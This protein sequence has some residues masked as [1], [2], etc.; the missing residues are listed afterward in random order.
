MMEAFL[1][2]HMPLATPK[3]Y[4]D[5]FLKQEVVG[6]RQLALATGHRHSNIIAAIRKVKADCPHLRGQFREWNDNPN[7]EGK[8]RPRAVMT[9]EGLI[10]VFARL[11]PVL[12]GI[13]M[14]VVLTE[15]LTLFEG[16]PQAEPAPDSEI[17]PPPDTPDLF[18]P[19]EPQPPSWQINA[20]LAVLARTTAPAEAKATLKKWNTDR[21]DSLHALMSASG[22]SWDQI[23][24]IY[25]TEDPGKA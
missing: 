25:G 22:A 8:A 5:K 17:R 12:R 7:P 21:L 4:F 18:K 9:R 24:P 6:S 19:G 20:A 14:N 16:Q 11:R 23:G 10:A 1:R 15:Y 13:T 2:D 3:L